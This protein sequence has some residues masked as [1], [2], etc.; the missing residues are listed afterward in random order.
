MGKVESNST[1]TIHNYAY[2]N[3]IYAQISPHSR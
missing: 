3:T 2:L 1:R